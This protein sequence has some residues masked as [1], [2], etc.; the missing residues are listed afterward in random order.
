[1]DSIRTE[2]GRDMHWAYRWLIAASA[3]LAL[4]VA[5]QVAA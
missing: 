5:I 4:G 3:M 2:G 1:V